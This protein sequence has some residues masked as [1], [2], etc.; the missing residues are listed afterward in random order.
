MTT[1]VNK[2]SAD[3]S[4]AFQNKTEEI[5]VY[6]VAFYVDKFKL[7]WT[8]DYIDH[9]DQFQTSLDLFRHNRVYHKDQFG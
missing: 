1:D 9:Y 7:I 2:A 6:F 4:N 3:V 5:S 8:Q